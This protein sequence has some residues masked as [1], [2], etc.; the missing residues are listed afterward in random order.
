MFWNYYDYNNIRGT[1]L[2]KLFELQTIRERRDYCLCVLMFRYIHGL[3]PH[4]ISNDVTVVVN[5]HG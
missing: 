2:V 1:D 4:N 5:T 3:A